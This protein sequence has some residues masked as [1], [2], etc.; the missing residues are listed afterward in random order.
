MGQGRGK[1]GHFGR[2]RFL[3]HQYGLL[4]ANCGAR[5]GEFRFLRWN[6]LE[7]K[8]LDDGTQR[9]VANVV[10]KTGARQVVFNEG[11]EEYVKR[12]YD[13][14]KR[15]L[16]D[17]PPYDGLVIC[18]RDGTHIGSLKRG[19]QSLLEFC[20]LGFDSKGKSGKGKGN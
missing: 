1:W 18:K 6:D 8:T 7:T 19:F 20:N 4:L 11:S 9:L 10:G 2:D 15:Q 12:I 5:V 14:R 13:M 17:N 3:V 16:N